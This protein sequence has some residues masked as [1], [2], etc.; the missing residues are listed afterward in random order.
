MLPAGDLHGGESTTLATDLV[1]PLGEIYIEIPFSL[2][3]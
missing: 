1:K 2:P 3:C